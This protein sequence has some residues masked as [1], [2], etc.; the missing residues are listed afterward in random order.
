MRGFI[1]VSVCLVALTGEAVA[2]TEQAEQE[3][4]MAFQGA[5]VKATKLREGVAIEFRNTNRAQLQDM[6]D[7]L[8]EVADMIEQQ[9]TMTQTASL[10]DAVEFPPVDLAVSDIAQGARVTV[11]AARFRDI[12][13]LQELAFGFAEFWK[14][15]PCSAT[16]T[17]AR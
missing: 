4:P 16:L 2:E 1:A 12:P 3:C 15:S 17:A 13:A 9:S 14:S 7:Q 6:R 11:R 8:R 10:D 5:R